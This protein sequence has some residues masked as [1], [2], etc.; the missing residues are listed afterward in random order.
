MLNSTMSRYSSLNGTFQNSKNPD[1]RL[2][3]EDTC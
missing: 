1:N 3:L 2:C